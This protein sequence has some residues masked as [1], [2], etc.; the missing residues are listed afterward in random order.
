LLSGANGQLIRRLL[1]EAQGDMFGASIAASGDLNFDGIPDLLI[2]APHG[3]LGGTMAGQAYLYSGANGQILHKFVG[4]VVKGE[5]GSAL[6]AGADLDSDGLSDLAIG[7]P[8]IDGTLSGSGEPI[9]GRCYIFHSGS[10]VGGAITISASSA[11]TYLAPTIAGDGFFGGA[12]EF[13]NDADSDGIRD[14]IIGAATS[15]PQDILEAARAYVFSGLTGSLIYTALATDEPAV[16]GDPV[17]QCLH[18]C[19]QAYCQCVA[20]ARARYRDKLQN[21]RLALKIGAVVCG[22]VCLIPGLNVIYCLGC[23]GAVYGAAGGYLYDIRDEFT[24][25]WHDCWSD[26]GCTGISPSPPWLPGL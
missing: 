19:G 18:P 9:S 26:Q 2:G 17:Q 23:A 14:V 1:G 16:A 15:E 24:N 13:G 3:S 20:N 22:G 5:F 7:A 6:A 8:R 12:V 11:N 21:L 4:D 10:F 25:R